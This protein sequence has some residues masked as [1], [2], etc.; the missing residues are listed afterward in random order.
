MSRSSCTSTCVR[1]GRQASDMWLA[2]MTLL[3]VIFVT[4]SNAV[5]HIILHLIFLLLPFFALHF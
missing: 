1:L 3:P 4:S 5:A 2:V